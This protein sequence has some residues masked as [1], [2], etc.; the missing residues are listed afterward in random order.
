[1]KAGIQPRRVDYKELQANLRKQG[2][3]LPG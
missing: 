3:N 1:V 2:V